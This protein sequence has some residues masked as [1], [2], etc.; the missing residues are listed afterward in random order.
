MKK[1]VLAAVIA[2]CLVAAPAA[3]RAATHDGHAAH[4]GQKKSARRAPRRAAKARRKAPAQAAAVFSC[5]MH[6]DVRSKTAGACPKCGM[7]MEAKKRPG[8]E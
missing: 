7:E 5:P 6:P 2:S 4:G 3:N 8:V 1:I